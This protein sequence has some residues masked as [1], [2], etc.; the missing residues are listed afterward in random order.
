M[1]KDQDPMVSLEVHV[2]TGAIGA[3]ED[4]APRVN[5]LNGITICELSNRLWED[6]R[7]FP[8]I[9][10]LLQKHYPDLKII[11][12][13]EFPDIYGGNAE[14]YSR[15]IIEKKCDAVIVGTAG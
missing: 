9:R 5:D 13:D 14:E 7:I 10:E 1:M 8:R 11:P 3:A 6:Y 4:L 12:Y 2:P 15:M